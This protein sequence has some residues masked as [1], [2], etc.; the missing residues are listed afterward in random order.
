MFVTFSPFSYLFLRVYFIMLRI[1]FLTPNFF[2]FWI[3][4][5]FIILLFIGL[6]YSLI[7]NSFSS[8]ILFFLL[9]TF[10]SFGLLTF[11][12]FDMSFFFTLSFLLKLSIVPFHFWVVRI[13][14]RLPNFITGLSLTVHK[15][16]VFLIIIYF[17]T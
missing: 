7:T 14:Y 5:E 11:Y 9:Q 13:F 1:I 4:I 17:D 16:P 6:R 8:L 2:I 15:M 3:I 12:L 10:S